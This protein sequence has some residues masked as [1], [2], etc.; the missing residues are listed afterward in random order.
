MKEFFVDTRDL[1]P[2]GPMQVVL[3]ELQSVIKGESFLHQ[4]HRMEPTGVI[5]RLSSMGMDYYL[6]NSKDGYHIYYFYKDDREA[7][8]KEID[9]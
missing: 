5:N 3:S 6:K 4:L 2:P 7:V 8:L 1:E 9:V